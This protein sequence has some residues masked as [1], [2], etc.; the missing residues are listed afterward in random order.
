M[1]PEQLEGKEADARSDLFAFGA[2]LYEMAT[3]RRAFDG[4]SQASLITSIMSAAP[5]PMAT[6]VPM[7][8]PALE[9]VVRQ[10]LAKEPD[11]RWQ[12]AGDLRRELAWIVN[13]GSQAGAPAPVVAKRRSR[14]RAGWV[15]AAVA[16]TALLIT[17]PAAIAHLRRAPEARP[18]VRFFVQP[19]ERSMLGE[20]IALAPDGSSLAFSA[21]ISGRP[22]LW[23]RS[24]DSLEARAIA[25]TEGAKLPF[26]SPDGRRI[27]FFAL[28]KLKSVDVTTGSVQSLCDA[29]EGRGGSWGRD[30]KILFAPNLSTAIS[31]VPEGGG[32]ATPVT[33]MDAK[34]RESSHRWPH[35]L[36]DGRHFL[37][38]SRGS[39]RENSRTILATLGST[40]TREILKG[41]SSVQYVDPGYLLYVRDGSLFAHR[42]DASRLELE[43]EPRVLAQQVLQ[44]GEEGPTGSGGFSAS[45]RGVLVFE[46]G[47][48]TPR[49]LLWFD[50]KGTRL[51]EVGLPGFYDEPSLTIDAGR[52]AVGR[53]DIGGGTSDI[54]ILEL[55]RGTFSRLTFDPAVDATPIFSPS[56]D[57]IAFSSNRTGH[58]GLYWKLA[59][60]AG[61]DETLVPS[62]TSAWPDDWS[63]DSKLILYERVDPNGGTNLWLLDTTG[64]RK[65]RPYLKGP[66]EEF[67]GQFSP[68]AKYVSYTSDESGRRE[69]YVQTL[70]PSGGK[71]QISTSGGGWS[72]WRAD[73]R[74]MYYA[75]ADMNLMAVSVET[76]AEFKAGIPRKLF[77]LPLPNTGITNSRNQ[78]AMASDG[79]KVLVNAAAE[80]SKPTP[81]TV[82]LNWTAVLSGN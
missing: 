61:E 62:E 23:L 22:S 65:T 60:G 71:W 39:Q 48:G 58:F 52:V 35:L 1:A 3:G 8:P 66:M 49:Q 20:G 59:S 2:V 13:A 80:E 36:P 82:V 10:C 32:P 68:D 75:D 4:K 57:R 19:P 27:G 9:R 34:A 70:P 44:Y 42:F 30:G 40:E 25:G 18:V 37:F 45:S 54:W 78:Y 31:I 41:V 74:E 21:M 77:Q 56:G 69:V 24:L 7:T 73:G 63:R 72:S 28:G 81:I 16:V 64:D 51:G 38:F 11:D 50:R 33:T 55:A 46:T 17:L 14:E 67:H 26:W 76:G 47:G 79:Q 6:L 15:A 5:P 43:G 53:A 29:S 12:S